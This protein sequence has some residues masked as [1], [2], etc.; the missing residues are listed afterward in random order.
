MAKQKR[1]IRERAFDDSW[2]LMLE[3]YFWECLD[4]YFPEISKQIDK[5]KGYIP[6]TRSAS[7]TIVVAVPG[8]NVFYAATLLRDASV[9]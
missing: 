8:E 6:P 5:K 1:K 4:F 3:K 7:G 9:I 2:K